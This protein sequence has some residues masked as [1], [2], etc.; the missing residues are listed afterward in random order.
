[1]RQSL[2]LLDDPERWLHKNGWASWVRT[3]KGEFEH[4]FS[5]VLPLSSAIVTYYDCA[6]H[7]TAAAGCEDFYLVVTGFEDFII[8]KNGVRPIN[9]EWDIT[10][11]GQKSSYS[12]TDRLLV[13]RSACEWIYKEDEEIKRELLYLNFEFDKRTLVLVDKRDPTTIIRVNDNAY[14]ES[15]SGVENKFTSFLGKWFNKASDRSFK[16][17]F[18]GS[19]ECQSDITNPWYQ[20]PPPTVPAAVQT[21]QTL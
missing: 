20:P 6:A 2:R 19:Y 17:Y 12:E 21:V 8:K 9:V 1:M 10:F 7:P 4:V 16:D 11:A 13:R 3:N 15:T 18:R 14:I 5:E